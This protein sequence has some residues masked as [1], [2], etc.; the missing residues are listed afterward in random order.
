MSI[1]AGIESLTVEGREALAKRCRLTTEDLAERL[2]MARRHV[3]FVQA[4]LIGME[5][6]EP[7]LVAYWRDRL[8]RMASGRTSRCRSIP[9]RARPAIARCGAGR[10]I[11]PGNARMTHYLRSLPAFSDI[12]DQRPA[13]L[14]ELEDLAWHP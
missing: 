14:V 2:F 7:A 3:P 5:Q 12:Q 1:E 11:S 9:I 13:R 10:T 4:N 8:M 6:D